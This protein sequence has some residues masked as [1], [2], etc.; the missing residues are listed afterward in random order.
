MYIGGMGAQRRSSFSLLWVAIHPSWWTTTTR[1]VRMTVVISTM[2]TELRAAFTWL[3]TQRLRPLRVL[4]SLCRGASESAS[5]LPP[6]LAA[7]ESWN[8]WRSAV[9]L[10]S[11]AV[12]GLDTGEVPGCLSGPSTRLHRGVEAG[13]KYSRVAWGAVNCCLLE[14][15]SP[16]STDF[17]F[18]F[19]FG[20]I[21]KIFANTKDK[22]GQ[23]AT[24]QGPHLVLIIISSELMSSSSFLEW[25]PE[26]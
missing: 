19:F 11:A 6:E 10:S 5:S 25:I 15:W 2:Q 23:A 22:V 24:C 1:T 9:I 18:G 17:H 13:E 12:A 8:A 14:Q 21:L 3:D 7:P 4:G 16:N 20:N 26:R